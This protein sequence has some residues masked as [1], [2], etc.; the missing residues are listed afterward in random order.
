MRNGLSRV[1]KD[2]IRG[3]STLRLDKGPSRGVDICKKKTL[4]IGPRPGL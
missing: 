4:K 1:C 3:D 2:G